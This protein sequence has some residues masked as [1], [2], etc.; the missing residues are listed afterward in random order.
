LYSRRNYTANEL[1]NWKNPT[2][3]DFFICSRAY[4]DIRI[5]KKIEYLIFG[6]YKFLFML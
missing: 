4:L 1:F 6:G 3:R 2:W 5:K